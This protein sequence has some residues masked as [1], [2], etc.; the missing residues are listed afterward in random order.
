MHFA[1][2]VKPVEY[3]GKVIFSEN[4]VQLH[5]CKRVVLL[6]T[7]AT[8]FNGYDKDPVR[9]GRDYMAIAHQ[10]LADA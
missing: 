10:Q 6:I 1:T 5:D 7:A 9:E 3:D 4:K 2:L 8:S